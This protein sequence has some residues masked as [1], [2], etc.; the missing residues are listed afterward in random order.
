MSFFSIVVPAFNAIA[1]VE[2][3]VRSLLNQTFKD[4]EIIA[5]DDG[6]TDNTKHILNKFAEKIH[7]LTQPHQG[8]EIARNLGIQNAQGEY[9]V[10]FDADDILFP[11]ALNVYHEIIKYFQNPPLILSKMQYFI[12]KEE[13]VYDCWDESSIECIEFQD[14]LKKNIPIGTSNSKIIARKDSVLKVGGYQIDIFGEDD[15]ALLFRLGIESPMIIIQYP[16]TVGYRIHSKNY[17]NDIELI[18]GGALK[19]ITSERRNAYPGGKKRRMD[20]RGLIGSNVLSYMY[21]KILIAKNYS[22]KIRVTLIVKLMLHS[23][24]ML[25]LGMV[26]KIRSLFYESKRHVIEI[27]KKGKSIK[28]QETRIS[29]RV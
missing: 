5:V 12:N 10:S 3:T 15:R 23:R 6:S 24:M 17:S 20:R 2:E 19:L 27:S 13:I 22:L 9:I 16:I 7:I 29:N 26:R 25:I 11:H 18:T 4:Y 21:R 14:F 28:A 1:F 8:S